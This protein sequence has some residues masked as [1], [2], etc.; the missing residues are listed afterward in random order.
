M[1]NL[2]IK[3]EIIYNGLLQKQGIFKKN[4]IIAKTF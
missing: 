1:F 4:I 3:M 2:K